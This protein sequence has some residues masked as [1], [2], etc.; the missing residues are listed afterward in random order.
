MS[1]ATDRALLL[2]PVAVALVAAAPAFAQDGSD[3]DPQADVLERGRY[4]LHAGGCITCHTVED[5]AA[6]FLAGGRALE[7]P[8]GTFYAPN[9][10]PDPDTG[11]GRWSDEPQAPR[12]RWRAHRKSSPATRGVADRQIPNRAH[13]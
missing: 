8:F 6:G 1:R 13:N 11:S 10:T 4:I 9:I 3:S 2:I 7:S 12:K 5:D